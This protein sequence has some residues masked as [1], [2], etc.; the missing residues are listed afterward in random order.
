V[1]LFLAFA[2]QTTL[3]MAQEPP[4]ALTMPSTFNEAQ[5]LLCPLPSVL[6]KGPAECDVLM[7][8][9]HSELTLTETYN[10]PL[11]KTKAAVSEAAQM[12]RFTSDQ[13][14]VYHVGFRFF[15]GA[16]MLTEPSGPLIRDSSPAGVIGGVFEAN[17]P[18]RVFDYDIQIKKRKPPIKYPV[19]AQQ[20]ELGHV[21]CIVLVD[22][23]THG[24]PT[25]LRVTKCPEV[26][27]SAVKTAMMKWRWYPFKLDKEKI[28][29]RFSTRVTLIAPK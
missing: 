24:A 25:K 15:E 6:L 18:K 23:D 4:C 1:N 22:L 13:N 21:T 16:W 10:C 28:P 29:V 8:M 3:A 2:L 20:Q 26:F 17:P 12:W 11:P 14:S 7:R 5:P 19:S 27:H 9:I